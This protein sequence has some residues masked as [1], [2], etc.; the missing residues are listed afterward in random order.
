M[1][2]WVLRSD[3]GWA[4]ASRVRCACVG[5]CYMSSEVSLVSMVSLASLGI[6]C[7]LRARLVSMV[8]V[9]CLPEKG[10]HTFRWQCKQ[11]ARMAVEWAWG[12]GGHMGLA[13]PAGRG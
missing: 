4:F 12:N 9:L 6:V 5:V 3:L 1:F 10:F 7:F 8:S 13:L 2:A 11:V